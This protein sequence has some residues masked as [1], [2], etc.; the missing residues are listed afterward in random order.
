MPDEDPGATTPFTEGTP[1]TDVLPKEDPKGSEEPPKE[2]PVESPKE[3]PPKEDPPKEPP[4]EDTTPVEDTPKEPPKEEPKVV[5][6]NA[7][8][9]EFPKGVPKEFGEFAHKNGFTQEQATAALT[10]F[11]GYNQLAEQTRLQALRTMGEK[12]LEDWGD[13][14]DFN[15][16]LAQRAL[17]QNDPDGNLAKTLNTSGYGNHPAV[18]EFLYR[19]GK[20]MQEGGFLKTAI[21]RPKGSKSTAQAMYPSMASKET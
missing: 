10:Q 2:P 9:Y 20:S 12:H 4:K 19:I 15:L 1:V 7:D 21:N 13:K 18:L 11:A 3:D 8:E 6:P 17:K 16:S 14:K 5:N